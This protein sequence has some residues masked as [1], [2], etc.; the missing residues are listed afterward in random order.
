MSHKYVDPKSPGA[1]TTGF[2][3]HHGTAKGPGS[4]GVRDGNGAYKNMAKG[5][6]SPHGDHIVNKYK[7]RGA[8]PSQFSTGA[9]LNDDGDGWK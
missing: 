8:V 4:G 3:N 6:E 7:P 9:E 2:A 5:G 1:S